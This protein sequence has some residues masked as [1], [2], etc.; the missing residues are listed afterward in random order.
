MYPYVAPRMS[1]PEAPAPRIR[2]DLLDPA[3]SS[4]Q[5]LRVGPG[6]A[7]C[8]RGLKRGSNGIRY[9]LQRFR[10]VSLHSA[11]LHCARCAID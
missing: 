10:C 9:G 1:R 8:Q 4:A 7:Q 11:A 5:G 6:P 2:L 3:E